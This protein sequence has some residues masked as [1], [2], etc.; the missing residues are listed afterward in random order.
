MWWAVERDDSDSQARGR[1]IGDE[2]TTHLTGPEDNVQS[3]I[4]HHRGSI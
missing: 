3:G 1:Q 2:G 4:G